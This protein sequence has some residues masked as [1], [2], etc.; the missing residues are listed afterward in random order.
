MRCLPPRPLLPPVREAPGSRPRKSNPPARTNACG[1]RCWAFA[2]GDKT[3]LAA[4]KKRADTEVAIIVDVDEVIGQKAVD[5][6]E[7]ATGKRPQYLK[8]MR[9]A[10]DDKSIDW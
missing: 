7:K 9:Q 1:W 3:H 2:A 10:F 4:Y 6:I 8:D 5:D